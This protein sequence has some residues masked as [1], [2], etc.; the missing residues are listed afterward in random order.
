[1]Y[2]LEHWNRRSICFFLCSNEWF[3]RLFRYLQG[4]ADMGSMK[5]INESYLIAERRLELL[6]KYGV[7]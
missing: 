1:M 7:I 4:N 3:K 2:R 5:E 6:K